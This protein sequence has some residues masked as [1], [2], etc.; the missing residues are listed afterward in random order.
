[1]L[2]LRIIK[3][4]EHPHYRNFFVDPKLPFEAPPKTTPRRNWRK[5]LSIYEEN[6][7]HPLK[8]VNLVN[9]GIEVPKALSAELTMLLASTSLS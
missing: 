3:K 5:L 6:S 1:M 9:I 8:P 4:E 7:G 2:N